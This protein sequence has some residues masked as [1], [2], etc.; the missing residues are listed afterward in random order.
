MKQQQRDLSGIKGILIDVDGTLVNTK[1]E[2]SAQTKKHLHR[3]INKGYKLGVCTGR[4]YPDLKNSILNLFPKNSLHIVDDGGLIINQQGKVLYGSYLPGK[5]VK[6]ICKN[7]LEMG[8]DFG[9]AHGGVKYYNQPFLAHMQSKDKWRKAIGE[10]DMLKD[11]STP[12]LGLYNINHKIEN[13]LKQL[14][15]N[16]VKIVGSKSDK[17]AS[18]FLKVEG[19]NVNKGTAAIKWA[20]FNNLEMRQ[21]MMLGDSYND[22]EVM[23]LVGVAVAMGNSVKEI[24]EVANIVVK[25]VDHNGLSKFLAQLN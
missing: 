2:V 23:K 13:Y 10:P 5:L 3:L 17:Y 9:F 19:K 18:T 6:K 7:I 25:D 15:E 14:K 11:W 22:L 12:C 8:G 24:K 21:I 20:E 4:S 16:G 1:K